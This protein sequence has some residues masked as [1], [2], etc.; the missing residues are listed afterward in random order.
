[1]NLTIDAGNTSIK[2]MVF[3]DNV[4]VFRREISK[5]SLRFLKELF[6]KLPVTHSIFSAVISVDPAVIRFLKK[7]SRFILLSEKTPIPVKNRYKTPKT[8]GKDRL[9]AA[10]A[11]NFLFPGKNVLVID[12]GTCIKYDL[13]TAK[14]HY[15]GG[16]ISPGLTMRFQALHHFTGQLPL[17][18]YADVKELT[19]NSTEGAI[20]S[21]VVLGVREELK[22]IISSY[23]K[24]YPSLKVVL[25]GGD[26]LRFAK[27]LNL[28][29]FVA[30]DLVSLGLNEI[31][32]YNVES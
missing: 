30:A 26:S 4:P 10:I 18:T 32:R 25:S 11:G 7:N 19:G 12:L 1:M 31:I 13:V 3:S 16:S 29:I 8:L 24:K 28:S 6:S 15:L 20:R 23:R 14:G 9:S 5:L 22:G 2:V 27:Q 21:G 17:I